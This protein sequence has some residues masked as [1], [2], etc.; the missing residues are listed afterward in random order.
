MK[1]CKGCDTV[2]QTAFYETQGS[3]YCK[4]CHRAKYFGKGRQ[5]RDA[6]KLERGECA[7]CHLKVTPENMPIFEFD[8]TRDKKYNVSQMTSMKSEK[9]FEEI[10][11]CV[12]L[13]SNCHR[14][15]TLRGGGYARPARG[16]TGRPRKV[17]PEPHTPA[18]ALSPTPLDETHT[19]IPPRPATDDQSRCATM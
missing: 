2:D 13:C 4:A 17:S 10:E 1:V 14:I 12:L 6:A 8:H 3:L 15:R 5:R 9:F 7:E 11:K 19:T 18:S 16:P